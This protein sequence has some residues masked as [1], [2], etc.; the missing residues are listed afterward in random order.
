[1]KVIIVTLLHKFLNVSNYM[2]Q[3]AKTCVKEQSIMTAKSKT[4]QKFNIQVQLRLYKNIVVMG[5]AELCQ[6]RLSATANFGG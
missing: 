3:K 1:M 4:Q 2:I 5:L 6:E